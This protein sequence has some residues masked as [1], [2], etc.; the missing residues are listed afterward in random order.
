MKRCRI[1]PAIDLIDG[2]CVRLRQGSFHEKEVVGASPV[3]VARAFAEQGFSRLHVVDL[4]GARS[5]APRHLDVVEA[6]AS[7]TGLSIDCSGG[8]RTLDDVQSALARGATQVVIGSAAVLRPEEV[9]TWFQ[10]VGPERFILGLDVLNGEVRVKGW[11][12]GSSLSLAAIL[13]R[14]AESG[15]RQVMS[16]DIARDGMLGGPAIGMYE[17]LCRE[18]SRFEFIAS[19]G[20]ASAEDVQALA[21]TGVGEIIVG[22]A[23]YAGTLD[24]D[25]VR[26]FVW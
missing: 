4:D 14:F 1:V 2:K 7:E 16:T 9:L 3:A 15:L 11:E 10:A 22:K 13:A 18:Y 20:V 23:L 5:G 19:G 8:L 6:I 12:E 26:E 24:V 17:E 21:K 25:R